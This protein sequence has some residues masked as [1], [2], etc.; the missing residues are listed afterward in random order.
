MEAVDLRDLVSFAE[1]LDL[2]SPAAI[3]QILDFAQKLMTNVGTSELTSRLD[4]L[5]KGQA[6]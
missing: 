6:R 2:A 3:S 1:A 5:R 4:S